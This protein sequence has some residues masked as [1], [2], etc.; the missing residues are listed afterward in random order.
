VHDSDTA[1]ARQEV[2]RRQ[3]RNLYRQFA[4]SYS[5]T[6]TPARLLPPIMAAV[7]ALFAA[8]AVAEGS[9]GKGRTAS[10]AG[11]SLQLPAGWQAQITKTPACDPER[12]IVASS[13]PTHIAPSGRLRSP[14]AGAVLV[15]LLEDRY[16]QDR[17][18]GD[19]RRQHFSVNCPP[20]P[21]TCTTSR[22]TAAISATSSIRGQRWTP[23][24]ARRQSHSWT[25]C[26][27]SH[28]TPGYEDTTPD[29]DISR[30]LDPAAGVKRS[31]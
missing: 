26:T 25:A 27:S 3:P 20:H 30:N 18:L 4:R 11:V 17:P 19:L 31:T 9:P 12:L 24:R 7:V 22:R 2:P 14:P 8:S 5:M 15:V 29:I 21:H 6:A 16:R 23:R 28:R 13:T 1:D 10:T